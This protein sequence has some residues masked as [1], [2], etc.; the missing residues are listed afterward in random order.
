MSEKSEFQFRK[1][2]ISDAENI[3]KIINVHAANDEMLPRSLNQVYETLRD[4][5]VCVE[6]GRVIGCCALHIMWSDL[7]ELRS[8]AVES[9]HQG[10]GIGKEFVRLVLNEAS[11][12][13]IPRVF[14]LTYKPDY[15]SKFNFRVIDKHILPHKVWTDCINCPKFPDC[16][17][18]AMIQEIQANLSDIHFDNK[19][20]LSP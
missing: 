6:D 17:E 5:W 12:L 16:G 15:F 14:L 1:A 9:A 3:R 11:Q 4:F 13:E 10:R 7:A 8:M 18:V 20:Q 2:V 19:A